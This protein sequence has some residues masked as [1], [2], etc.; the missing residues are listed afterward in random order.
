MKQILQPI[1]YWI[2]GYV[3]DTILIGYVSV[4]YPEKINADKLD[5]F[6]ECI[7]PPWPINGYVLAHLQPI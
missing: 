7:G 2:L 4:E 1:P 6:S 5:T 3:S